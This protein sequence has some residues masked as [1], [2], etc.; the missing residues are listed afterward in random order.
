M[1]SGLAVLVL[2]V[3]ALLAIP[4]TLTFRLSWARA[5]QGQVSLHWAFGLVHVRLPSPKSESSTAPREK[6]E[7]SAR[8]TRPGKGKTKIRPLLRHKAFRRR[9]ARFVRDFWRAF[10]KRDLSL[11]LRIGLGDPADTGRLWAVVGPVAGMLAGNR[12]ASLAIVPEFNDA[13][14][15]L[16]G[17]GS[18]RFIPL[19]LLYLM[20]ALLLSP[21]IWQGIHQ[22]RKAS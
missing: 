12:D 18:I 5:V 9:I 3:L 20:F 6:Q 13:A 14:F 17:H 16:N 22:A 11:R 15:E 21:S 2:V 10:D 19:Q 1:L 8:A 4:I 7:R